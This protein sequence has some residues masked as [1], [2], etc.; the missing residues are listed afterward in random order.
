MTVSNNPP[1][2]TEAEIAKRLEARPDLMKRF[3]AGDSSALAELLEVGLD[4]EVA[5]TTIR[6]L[7]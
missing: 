5:R 6:L 3:L 7:A 2:L 1:Q 4:T